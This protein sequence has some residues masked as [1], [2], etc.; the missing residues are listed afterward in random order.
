MSLFSALSVAIT[1][2]NTLNSAVRVV[3]DNVSNATNDEYNRRVSQFANL[4]FGGVQLANVER[5]ANEGLLRD[6]FQQTTTAKADGTRDELFNQLEQLFGTISGQTPLAD[7]TERLRSAFKALEAS[8]ESDA[9]ENDV[10]IAATQLANELT[11][12]SDGLDLIENQVLRDIEDTVENMNEALIE[13]DRL[14]GS[15]AVEKAAGRP[16]SNLENLRDAQVATIAEVAKIRTFE[17]D[18]GSLSVYLT[19]GLV[20]VDSEPE[21]FTWNAATQTLTLS[22]SSST[23]LVTGGQ[24]PDGQLAAQTNFLRTDSTALSSSN[25]GDAGLEK[26]RNQLDEFAFSLADDSTA[27]TSGTT[28]VQGSAS[29]SGDGLVTAGNTLTFTIGGTLLGTVTI[30][31]GDS[32][33]DVVTAINGVTQMRARVDGNG[34]LQ[35]LSSGGA[36]TIGGTAATELGLSTTQVSAD[37]E[38]TFSYAYKAER[39]KGT[40]PTTTTTVL[41]AINGIAVGDEFSFNNTDLGG[42]VTFTVGAGDTVQDLLN[43]VNAREGMYARI[44]DGNVLE[45]SS[46]SGSLALTEVTNTPLTALGFTVNG[47]TASISGTI[48]TGESNDFFVAESGTTPQDVTRTNFA[49]A[50]AL[51]SNT[52]NVKTGTR[53]EVV[54]SFNATIRSING[55]GVTLNNASYTNLSSGILTNL[56]QNAERATLE[57][58]E[59]E[60]LRGNLEQALRDEVGVNIDEE[61]ANLTVLQ[62][63]Y[64]ATARVID[65]INQ[66][67]QALEL[68][69]R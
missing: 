34:H 2:V 59:S 8:P 23:N 17:R 43:F 57:A 4:Q 31:A 10:L 51:S 33:D 30:N 28:F 40:V 14:N 56:T 39:A 45:I 64:A 55:S 26:L 49:L 48:Q 1:S 37:A 68:A 5:A 60:I 22:G 65:T 6:L 67:F 63:A 12:L 50:T 27:R 3:S 47:T 66:M 35:V 29:L 32:I 53:T 52:S 7:E 41:S 19:T 20:L 18:D 24:L 36:F 11:R 62:N 21:S 16:T 25:I 54:E 42:A 46:K 13:I 58:E 9:A 44:G 69:G 61:M 15:I 38:D